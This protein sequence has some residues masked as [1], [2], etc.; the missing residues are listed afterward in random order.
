MR[1]IRNM[2]NHAFTTLVFLVFT[3]TKNYFGQTSG[4]GGKSCIRVTKG[5]VRKTMIS[6]PNKMQQNLFYWFF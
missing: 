6:A 5:N 4:K 3:I 1:V 2:T